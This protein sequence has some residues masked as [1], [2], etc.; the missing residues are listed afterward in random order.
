M[1]AHSDKEQ[2]ITLA[3]MPGVLTCSNKL[4]ENHSGDF[5]IVLKAISKC[6]YEVIHLEKLKMS[7]IFVTF[8]NNLFFQLFWSIC[9][10]LKGFNKKQLGKFKI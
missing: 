8:N 9:C 10:R 3:V 1:S 4:N 5:F 7:H 2:K 6:T